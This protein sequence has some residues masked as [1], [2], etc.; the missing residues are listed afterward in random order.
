MIATDQERRRALKACDACRIGPPKGIKLGPRSNFSKRKSRST[1][2]EADEQDVSLDL[3]DLAQAVDSH[4]SSQVRSSTPT[5]VSANDATTTTSG[6]Q[7]HHNAEQTFLDYDP[8]VSIQ[9][10]SSPDSSSSTHRAIG[11]KAAQDS[12]QSFSNLKVTAAGVI[13]KLENGT[14]DEFLDRYWTYIHTVWPLIYKPTFD[15]RTASPLLLLSM[16]KLACLISPPCPTGRSILASACPT[17]KDLWT[18]APTHG[19][20]QIWLLQ[21]L[22]SQARGNMEQASQFALEGVL[23]LMRIGHSLITPGPQSEIDAQ[24]MSRAAWSI[25]CYHQSL[26]QAE[27]R[28]PILLVHSIPCALPSIME[29][30]E[31]EFWPLITSQPGL[32]QKALTMTCFHQSCR[33]AAIGDR[34]SSLVFCNTR[35]QELDLGPDGL[36]SDSVEILHQVLDQWYERL[37]TAIKALKDDQPSHFTALIMVSS[38]RHAP[39]ALHAAF[40]TVNIACKLSECGQLRQMGIHVCSSLTFALLYLVFDIRSTNPDAQSR[41]T[42]SK[43]LRS[44]HE[45]ASYGLLPPAKIRFF[46]DLTDEMQTATSEN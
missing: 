8:Y 43:G 18:V 32:R 37:P 6:Y 24:S 35:S 27:N 28:R 22:I 4:L 42:A 31:L 30:D 21:A 16:L 36:S 45:L 12:T 41:V 13:A 29:T 19:D 9:S 34:V 3:I 2:A 14:V 5:H 11:E 25:Y 44:L 39:L 46:T 38:L 10:S 26:S 1:S 17:I 20:L 40:E 23:A 15:K 7:S 33:L